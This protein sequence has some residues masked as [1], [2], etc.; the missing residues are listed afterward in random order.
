LIIETKDPDRDAVRSAVEEYVRLYPD[1]AD[2]I[3][4]YGAIMEAQ[5]EVLQNV[6]CDM[7]PLSDEEVETRL[8]SGKTLLDVGDVP[9]DAAAYRELVGKICATVSRGAPGGLTFC[10]QLVAWEGLSQD[11]LPRTRDRLLAG[12]DLDFAGAGELSEDDRELAK[13]ILWEGLAPFYRACGRMLAVRLEQSLWQR[14]FC[15]VCGGAPLIGKYR[16]TDGLWVVECSL[17]H[18]G[19]NIQ[20][21]GCSVCD[22]SQ[23]SLDYLYL[24]EDPSRR[25][26][27][28]R[29]C[30]RYIK[31]VDLR[32]GGEEALLP[33]ENII[34][35]RLDEAAQGEGLIPASGLF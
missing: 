3:R 2:A 13:K 28:C 15:P 34:S 32:D 31:T 18:T 21:V 10:D 16:Q 7:Q 9:I 12:A 1:Y 25:A 11:M 35:M 8:L 33:L 4:T 29:E 6:V 23:G 27:Y 5:Q 22:G 14:A 20:R 30:K 19:W 26:C 17:C 24:E